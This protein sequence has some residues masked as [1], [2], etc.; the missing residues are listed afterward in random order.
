MAY[1]A[2]RGN[3][4]NNL[5]QSNQDDTSNSEAAKTAK[6]QENRDNTKNV[7]KNVGSMALQGMGVPAPIAKMATN[8]IAKNP[9]VNKALNKAS[10]K[11]NKNPLANK[12]IN[13]MANSKLDAAGKSS[14]NPGSSSKDSQ[15]GTKNAEGRNG[16]STSN[17]S[18]SNSNQRNSSP[19]RSNDKKDGEGSSK[20]SGSV[21]GSSLIPKALKIKLI[22]IG[23]A[24]AAGLFLIIV[25]F[26]VISSFNPF[27][28]V[29]KSSGKST[30]L[31]EFD[32]DPDSDEGKFYNKVNEVAAE[33][34]TNGTPFDPRL[35]ASV[36]TTI[37]NYDD[38]YSY[39]EATNDIETLA[40]FMVE[41][42]ITC[43]YGE[44][45]QH[46][47]DKPCPEGYNEVS[48]TRDINEKKFKDKL[49]TEFLKNKVKTLPEDQMESLV[50]DIY[51]L[52]ED[53]KELIGENQTVL[54]A[55]GMCTYNVD[56]KTI[57]N[58][59]VRLLQCDD[60]NRGEPIE[61]EELIDFEK[62]IMGVTYAE[63]GNGPLEAM[64]TEAIAARSFALTRAKDMGGNFNI[65]L[66]E[67]NGEM[68]L[69]IRSCTEDQVYCD[70]DKGCWSNDKNANGTVHSGQQAGKPYS[71]PPI[72]MDSPI[73]KAIEETKGTVLVD[74]SG[75]IVMTSYTDT[76]HQ[77]WNSLA[78]AGN[79]C[80]QILKK[81]YPNA[82]RLQASCSLGAATGEFSSWKQYGA[83]WSSTKLGP[84]G[85]TIAESGCLATSIAIQIARSG[86]RLFIDPFN[87]GVLVTTMAAH[88]G[89]VG[90]SMQWNNAWQFAA[91]DWTLA[92]DSRSSNSCSLSGTKA[93]KTNQIASYLNQGYYPVVAVKNEGHWVAIDHVEG[94]NV[95]MFDPGS[96]STLLWD[97]YSYTGSNRILL[98][99]G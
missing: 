85:D 89:F 49:K 17:N 24:A 10:D 63:N 42:T 11:I 92:C 25:V 34:N 75:N 40:N 50:T 71:K 41:N 30:D 66:Q 61:G 98:F 77:N 4:Q 93:N 53:Y 90:S 65:K 67:E 68:V 74:D 83:P 9:I 78:Q 86:T 16:Q 99:R 81:D 35:I 13:Q 45:T 82:S 58:I 32:I 59:K 21:E 22:L 54:A 95:Y 91:P 29:D 15:N 47:V 43:Q 62:Y 44:E 51:Q 57:S 94:D 48:R 52:I 96:S 56:N 37:N 72:P 12:A 38:N 60:D 27:F 55:G 3:N 79:D 2:N 20:V 6:Q 7:A 23:A 31:G 14:N 87:P 8:K 46:V 88:G 39:E 70:P 18:R 5:Q 80:F 28:G 69:S 33:Y 64:K 1:K 19:N 84:G 36:F 73:R 26:A 76:N 97:Q